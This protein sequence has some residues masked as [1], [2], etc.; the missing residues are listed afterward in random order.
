LLIGERSIEVIHR[1]L[2]HLQR[3]QHGIQPFSDRCEPRW[4]RQPILC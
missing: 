2:H 4:W 3:F 1:G